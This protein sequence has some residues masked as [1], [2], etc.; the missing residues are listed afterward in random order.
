[1]TTGKTSSSSSH[2]ALPHH[3][4]RFES[5]EDTPPPP[6]ISPRARTRSVSIGSKQLSETGNGYKSSDLSSRFCSIVL[7][8]VSYVEPEYLRPWQKSSQ[9]SAYGTGFV[10]SGRRVLTNGHVIKDATDI[11]LR[12]HGNSKRWRARVIC[13]G[14]DVDLAVLEVLGD[15]DNEIE[16]FWEGVEPIQWA[17]GLPLLQSSVN[18]VGY[19][20]GGR[21][22]CVTEGV[23]SRIDCSNYRIKT[24][25]AAPGNLLVIQIDAAINPGNSGGPCFDHAG[26][27]VGVAFQGMDGSD[28]QNVGYI[29]PTDIARNFL[30]AIDCNDDP[31]SVESNNA[32]GA[33]LCKYEGVQEIPYRWAPLQNKSLRKFLNIPKDGSGVVITSVSPIAQTYYDDFLQE[34]DVI[35]HIDGKSLGDDYTVSLRGDELMNADFLITGKRKEAP[36]VFDIIRDTVPLQ[37]KAILKPLKSN[38]P[39][40]HNH[41]CTPEWLIVGGL[42]FVPLTCPLLSYGSTDDLEESGYLKIYDFIDEHLAKFRE[43]EDKETIVLID[44]LTCDTNFGYDFKSSWRILQ[45]INGEDVK[46]MAHLYS[47][48]TNAC[49]SLSENG[50]TEDK[51]EKRQEGTENKATEADSSDASCEF[52]IFKFRDKSQIVLE[53]ADCMKSEEEILEQHGIP[54]IV[55]AGIVGKAEKR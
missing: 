9:G 31:T 15:D 22:I 24:A 2:N 53:T 29:I 37:I 7:L 8:E 47:I 54:S 6:I 18:V 55:S 19:P 32:G 46:N 17:A 41:D 34:N 11:R 1:M 45:N 51:E 52:L 23:V 4:Q 3:G 25:A 42:L 30:H 5:N 44:I 27:V 26:R 39:R 38:I 13:E 16:A 50:R 14:P 12:K 40:E 43:V 21:T 49:Q 35:T 33:D 10:I 28:A 20:T 36:T 48:Y